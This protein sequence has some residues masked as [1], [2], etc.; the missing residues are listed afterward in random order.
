[1]IRVLGTCCGT[2][3]VAAFVSAVSPVP[4]PPLHV[5]R[6]ATTTDDPGWPAVDT[7]PPAAGPLEIP[8]IGVV[9]TDY[10]A[11]MEALTAARAAAA[12][13]AAPA[14]LRPPSPTPVGPEP[15][16]V[17]AAPPRPTEPPP[18]AEPSA[19]ATQ[20]PVTPL[21]T[22]EQFPAEPSPPSTPTPTTPTTPSSSTPA[23]P[24][25]TTPTPA[26][27]EPPPAEENPVETTLALGERYERRDAGGAVVFS[28]TL[29]T[30]DTEPACTE[31]GSLPAENGRLIGLHVEVLHGPEAAADGES[32]PPEEPP[33]F[34][35]TDFGFVGADDVVVA[36]VGTDSA[37]ACLAD[38]TAWPAGHP[39]P[40]QLVEGTLVLDVPAATGTIVYRPASWPAGLRW[41]V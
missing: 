36:D 18:A 3:T 19:P 1:L 9:L 30:V 14:P 10:D 22:D 27:E 35:A 28:L 7:S 33:S 6:T 5:D 31:A 29:M 38:A 40:G 17:E 15:S 20:P 2:L 11:Q 34:S 41:Q 12:A 16:R 26:T 37:V 23:T 39:G 8:T 24:T 32:A 21:V 13:D 25:P 4:E